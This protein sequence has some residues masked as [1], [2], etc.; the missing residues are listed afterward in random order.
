MKKQITNMENIIVPPPMNIIVE[1][2]NINPK[3]LA[4]ENKFLTN[5]FKLRDYGSS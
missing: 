2:K 1:K 5:F 3:D 4:K